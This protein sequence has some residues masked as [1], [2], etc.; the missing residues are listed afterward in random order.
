MGGQAFKGKRGQHFADPYRVSV[1]GLAGRPGAGPLDT[2]HKEGEHPLWDER[3]MLPLDEAM[4]NNMRVYGTI[5]AV[6]VRKAGKYPE[7]HPN[8]GEDIIEVVEGRQRTRSC[9]RAV[10]LAKKAGEVAPMLKIEF[11]RADDV[12]AVGAM[13]SA[14]EQRRDDLPSVKA[15]KAARILALGHS[16][17]DVA[18]MFGVTTTA[19]R[20]WTKFTE[21]S[22][23]VKKAVDNNQIS[24]S[25]A[26]QFHGLA[27]DD[28]NEKLSEL[29][30]SG[31]PSVNNARAAASGKKPSGGRAPVILPKSKLKKLGQDQ[32]F[33][34][35][36]S[37]DAHALLAVLLGDSS[38]VKKVPGLADRLKV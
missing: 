8:A 19:V 20:Q 38:Y 5:E 26:I 37:E 28:Q 22:K 13:I 23:K 30:A 32:D 2:A 24:F 16:E 31:K 17:Q 35:G 27:A 10:E 18:N 4:A 1:I 25:A 33:I 11:Q 15:R 21:L 7:G 36:L 34:D 3:I 29:I 9:R 12:T 6:K 14:N